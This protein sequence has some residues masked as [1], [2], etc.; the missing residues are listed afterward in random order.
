MAAGTRSIIIC[1]GSIVVCRFSMFQ[2][3]F[4]K[5][6]LPVMFSVSSLPEQAERCAI[7]L[8][9]Y[10]F[11]RW[12]LGAESVCAESYRWQGVPAYRLAIRCATLRIL[13]GIEPFFLRQSFQDLQPAPGALAM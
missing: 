3:L 10:S 11:C 2:E 9:L 8:D 6:C 13:L 7:L 4:T 1:Q 5:H 12:Q